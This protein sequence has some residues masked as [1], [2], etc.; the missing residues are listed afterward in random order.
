[1]QGFANRLDRFLLQTVDVGLAGVLLVVPFLMGGRHPIGQ[2]ALAIL[3]AVIG[4]AWA[5][6]L[7]CTDKPRWRS[8]NA[9]FVLIAGVLLVLAQLA[10]WPDGVLQQ[11]A[12]QS[13]NLLP[14]WHASQS[15][16]VGLG[17]WQCISMVPAETRGG[18]A[19]FLAYVLVFC[20]AVQRIEVVD[21]VERILRWCAVAAIAMAAFGLVQYFTNN[22]KFYWVFDL[23]GCTTQWFVKGSFTNRNHFA[24]FLAM[25]AGPLLWWIQD[26]MRRSRG[27]TQTNQRGGS[28][29]FEARGASPNVSSDRQGDLLVHLLSLAFG[30]VLFACLLSLSRGGN[31]AMFVA[32]AICAVV[33]YQSS[34]LGRRFVIALGIA[35][36]LIGASLA[37]FGF[38]RVSDRMATVSSGS[39]DE[40]DKGAGRRKVWATSLD[41]IAHQPLLGTGVGTFV[42]VYP[43]YADIGVNDGLEFSHGENCYL[44]VGVETGIVGLLLVFV[45]IAF[46]GRWCA[47]GMGRNVP[48][49]IRLCASAV[50]ASLAASA[51]HGC[52]DFV[53]YVPACSAMIAVLAAC[54]FRLHQFAKPASAAAAWRVPR[55]AAAGAMILAMCL[56]AWMI[57]TL[58][59]PA[60]S[61]PYWNDYRLAMLKLDYNAY[62]SQNRNT[63]ASASADK[64][65]APGREPEQLQIA[66]LEQTL[67][68]QPMHSRAHLELA[69]AHLR[70]FDQLQTTAPNPMSLINVRDAV[71]QSKFPT[72][73]A[74]RTWLSR[75]VGDHVKHL[76]EAVQHLRQ[77]LALC[78]LHGRAYVYLA[79]LSFLDSATSHSSVY[80]EQ[81]L[82]VRPFDGTVLY[83]ASCEAY[84]SGDSAKWME[85]AKRAFHAGKRQQHRIIVDLV[86]H[87]TTEYL[88]V[89]IDFIVREFQPDVD[90]VRSLH[91]ACSGRCPPDQLAPLTRY[92]AECAEQ[93]ARTL[94]TDRAVATWFEAYTYY[95]Q[96]QDDEAALRCA[97]NAVQC[98]PGNYNAHYALGC[99]LLKEQVFAEAESHLR[100][101]LARS[102]NKQAIEAKLREVLKG[103]LDSQ[104]KAAVDTDNTRTR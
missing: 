27:R 81:A 22:G 88:P 3:A 64:A 43:S 10:S 58:L 17:V 101:C 12:P 71:V 59:G 86:N 75:A 30:V 23:A 96:L 94:P 45:G 98:D 99:C 50:A 73:Q 36:L 42:E 83:G 40:L 18:L 61:A 100:W 25:G 7:G 79:E 19:I 55:F 33:G 65:I 6:H 95:C 62:V 24:D 37:I 41:A 46:C 26:A 72:L 15:N 67:A 44:Q 53:W 104:L 13:V 54:G 97:R 21:D 60:I 39:L 89:L 85:Y 80:L 57:A 47:G 90:G 9:V 63:N 77:A 4:F 34:S 93:E 76:D 14:L 102:P 28:H 70:L 66:N 1:M 2:L 51:V 32:V 35:G 16:D 11:I 103:R 69:E 91:A 87:S 5:A 38:D 48:T 8:A 82:R 68:W 29:S 56:G 52:V 31:I 20:V 78:P 84:L 74:M 49:R 92:R